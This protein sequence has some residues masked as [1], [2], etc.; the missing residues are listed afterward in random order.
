[1]HQN[2]APDY[3]LR[4]ELEVAL[5][6]KPVSANVT[7]GVHLCELVCRVVRSAEGAFIEHEQ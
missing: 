4:V 6:T 7:A 1:M 2:C 5:P 3:C